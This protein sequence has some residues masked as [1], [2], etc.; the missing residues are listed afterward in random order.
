MQLA[1]L[2]TLL[3][4]SDPQGSARDWRAARE[5]HPLPVVGLDR[6]TLDKD[7]RAVSSGYDILVI[8]GAPQIAELSVAAIKCADL[9]VIPVQ[10]SPYDVWACGDLVDLLKARQEVTEGKP[11]AAFLI[12]RVIKNTQLGR[13]VS[14]ALR[15]FGLPILGETIGQRQAYPKTAAQGSTVLDEEPGNEAAREIEQ[16]AKRIRE[17]M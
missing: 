6:K 5:D 13:D 17:M 1:G 10:P 7:I 4:D 8:D 14:E 11:K 12:S 3:V 15:E 2:A 16:L 9:V